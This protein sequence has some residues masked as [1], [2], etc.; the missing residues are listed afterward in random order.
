MPSEHDKIDSQK[1]TGNRD[2]ARQLAGS[3]DLRPEIP[4]TDAPTAVHRND[5]AC[6][7]GQLAVKWP[8]ASEALTRTPPDCLG[9]HVGPWGPYAPRVVTVHPR[10]RI[11]QRRQ[12]RPCHLPLRCGWAGNHFS[13]CHEAANPALAGMPIRFFSTASRLRSGQSKGG[14]RATKSAMWNGTLGASPALRSIF[15]HCV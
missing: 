5:G 4:R 7:E 14:R 11:Q 3:G 6:D 15:V 9:G 12:E 10:E 1:V 13:H 2:Q 8:E